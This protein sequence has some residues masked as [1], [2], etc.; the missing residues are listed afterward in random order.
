MHGMAYH[1]VGILHDV[2]DLAAALGYTVGTGI[3]SIDEYAA[4]VR[5]QNPREQAGKS[6]L[7]GSVLAENR[8][9]LA[10]AYPEGYSIERIALPVI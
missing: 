6:A 2:A 10:L 5:C 1:V 7:A 4:A 8:D 9:H 3:P